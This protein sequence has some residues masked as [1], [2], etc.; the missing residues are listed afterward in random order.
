M[1]KNI[2]FAV[3]LLGIITAHGQE[4]KTSVQE[5]K[6]SVQENKMSVQEKKTSFFVNFTN[7]TVTAKVENEPNSNSASGFSIGLSHQVNLSDKFSIVPSIAYTLVWYKGEISKYIQI[8][9][10]LKME[11]AKKFAI[12]AGPK[13]DIPIGLDSAEKEILNKLWF[14]LAAGFE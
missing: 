1:N 13:I 14:S 9:L 8:P 7:N 5:N 2:F 3:M 6:M 4:N 12:L 11:L 10:F